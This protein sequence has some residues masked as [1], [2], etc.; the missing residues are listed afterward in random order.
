MI[1]DSGVN[2]DH[3]VRGD[4]V[5][6]LGPGAV[7]AELSMAG[8]GMRMEGGR[9]RDD[10]DCGSGRIGVDMA[11]EE[12]EAEGEAAADAFDG[13]VIVMTGWEAAFFVGCCDVVRC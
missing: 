10:F 1:G 12:V 8:G 4:R 13:D 11:E 6:P 5:N 3:G 9:T 7:D 2:G